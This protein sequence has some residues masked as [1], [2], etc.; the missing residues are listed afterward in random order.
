VRTEHVS[1]H[2]IFIDRVNQDKGESNEPE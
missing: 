2:D 1:L